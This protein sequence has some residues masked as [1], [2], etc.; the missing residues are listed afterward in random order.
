MFVLPANNPVKV[1]VAEPLPHN[2]MG[3]ELTPVN[4][5]FAFTVTLVAAEAADVQP[6]FV[7]VNV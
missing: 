2:A 4:V 5:G 6:P 3:L 1:I 7:T